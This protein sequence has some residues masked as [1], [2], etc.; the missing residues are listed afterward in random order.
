[1]LQYDFKDGDMLINPEYAGMH[2]SLSA[3]FL[4]LPYLQYTNFS[5]AGMIILKVS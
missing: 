1:M 3:F 2:V 5:C 4:K